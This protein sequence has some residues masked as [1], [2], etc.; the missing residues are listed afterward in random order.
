MCMMLIQC[1]GRMNLG[2]C[3][4]AQ[5][6]DIPQP[7]DALLAVLVDGVA[8]SL[9]VRGFGHVAQPVVSCD[10]LLAALVDHVALFLDERVFGQVTQPVVS[11]DALL[12]ALVDH[13]ALFLDERGFDRGAARGA[14]H[15]TI[16]HTACAPVASVNL[17][18]PLQLVFPVGSTPSRSSCLYCPSLSSLVV[19]GRWLFCIVF[20]FARRE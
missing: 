7:C 20:R 2:S 14:A 18:I 12:A 1:F 13:V 15:S 5:N 19:C 16:P 11:C 4:T 10:A 9:D 3:R 17:V 8:L 6:A